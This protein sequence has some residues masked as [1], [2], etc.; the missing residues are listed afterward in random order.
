[1]TR[2]EL[3][4][5]RANQRRKRAQLPAQVELTLP[6][7]RGHEPHKEPDAEAEGPRI[8]RGFAVVDFY[9]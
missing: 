6:L 3:P 8:E 7:P 5:G 9:I 2:I 1:M 4:R